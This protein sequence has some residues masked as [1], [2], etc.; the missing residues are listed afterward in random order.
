MANVT[1]T[2][3]L[4]QT[5]SITAANPLAGLFNLGAT[6]FAGIAG[7]DIA[8]DIRRAAELGYY[9]EVEKTRQEY[10]YGAAALESAKAARAAL[11]DPSVQVRLQTFKAPK[12]MARPVESSD[13]LRR[14]AFLAA[15]LALA[16]IVKGII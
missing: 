7:K 13:A 14:F 2:D 5:L 1:T 10:A 15:L 11:A 6:I 8:K 4:T 9:S 16:L 3:L 12:D